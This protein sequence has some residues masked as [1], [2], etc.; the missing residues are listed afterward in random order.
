MLKTQCA[1]EFAIIS[2]ALMWAIMWVW[3]LLSTFD[4]FDTSFEPWS[5]VRTTR[6]SVDW[7]DPLFKPGQM[8][9]AAENNAQMKHVFVANKF[10]IYSL[11]FEQGEEHMK[12]SQKPFDCGKLE[13]EIIDMS[14]LCDDYAS[15]RSVEEDGACCRPIVLI[16][17]DE[18][19]KIVDCARPEEDSLLKWSGLPAPNFIEVKPDGLGLIV[20]QESSLVVWERTNS[21][22]AWVPQ[23]DIGI[24][25]HD[26]SDIDYGFKD[27][28][29]FRNVRPGLLATAIEQVDAMSMEQKRAWHIPQALMPLSAGCM[30]KEGVQA[31]VL[32]SSGREVD[33]QY[34]L[35]RLDLHA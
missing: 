23:Y 4:E 33:S 21:T 18:F 8:A 14:A 30:M 9:C 12:S 20:E 31:L 24:K 13:G 7:P 3:V 17:N 34:Y 2:S 1:V 26:I 27:I 11:H 22:S 32:P 10:S 16:R 25:H 28:V 15:C 19:T 29:F 6:F 35:T 5:G